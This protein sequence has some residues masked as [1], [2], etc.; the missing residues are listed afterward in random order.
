MELKVCTRLDVV[1]GFIHGMHGNRI[2]ENVICI[3]HDMKTSQ[4]VIY[5]LF[6]KHTMLAKILKNTANCYSW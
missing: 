3:H 2:M 1:I 6:E 5:V 4:K